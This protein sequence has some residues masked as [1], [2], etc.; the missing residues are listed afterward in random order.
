MKIITVTNTTTE[1][2]PEE[3][4]DYLR[5][6]EIPRDDEVL[7]ES[8]EIAEL[9]ARLD[10]QRDTIL[11]LREIIR[12]QSQQISGLQRRSAVLTDPERQAYIDQAAV[13]GREVEHWRATA[14]TLDQEAEHW[15]A[16]ARTRVL[17]VH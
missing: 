4:V 16:V 12:S 14:T 10:N 2:T 17:A 5:D 9:Q 11:S 8:D 6:E 15:K 3:L 1:G 7:A 13:L